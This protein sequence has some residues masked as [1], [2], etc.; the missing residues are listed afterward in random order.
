MSNPGIVGD[1]TPFGPICAYKV[2]WGARPLELNDFDIPGAFIASSA[3]SNNI[4]ISSNEL[5]KLLQSALDAGKD[6]FQFRLQFN[7]P[8]SDSD[9]SPDSYWYYFENVHFTASF[10]R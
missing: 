10:T 9:N 6:R 3:L 4:T 2:D 7:Y 1:P 8:S 5:V